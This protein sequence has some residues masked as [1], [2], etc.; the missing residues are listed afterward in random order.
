MI[1]LDTDHLTV[2]EI[3]DSIRRARLVARLA[4]SA[5][6]VIGTTIINV[7]EQMR[8]WLASI[9]KERKPERQVRSYQRAP[10]CSRSSALSI[11]RCSTTRQRPYT[12]AN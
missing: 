3:P 2:L 6:D 9:A 11:L 12:A 10:V 8:G 7:E 1:L 4:L 5:D